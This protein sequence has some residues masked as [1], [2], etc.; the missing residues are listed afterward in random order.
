MNIVEFTAENIKRLKVVRI[1]PD[2]SLVQISGPN[3]SGKS[4]VLDCIAWALGGAALAQPVPIRKG[5]TQAY[6]KLDLGTFV[7]TR[8]FAEGKATTLTVESPDG[9]K[10]P[11]PQRLLDGLVGALSFDPLEFTRLKPRE[12]FD[13]L[14]RLTDLAPQLANLDA[15]SAADFEKRTIVNRKIEDREAQ[16]RGI[17]VPDG[18]P[19]VAPDVDAATRALVTAGEANTQL[20]QRRE[21]R[22]ADLREMEGLEVRADA[23]ADGVAAK[24][25][26]VAEGFD[27]EIRDLEASLSRAR[28]AKDR[29]VKEY[30]KELNNELEGIQRRARELEQ[31]LAAAAPLPDPADVPALQAAAQAARLAADG[32]KLRDRRVAV[33][34][35]ALDLKLE[36]QALTDRLDARKAQKA[37]MLAAA[38]L[39]VPDLGLADG[40]VTLHG[41]PLEQASDAEQ[42]RASCAVAMAA[43][44]KLR[45]LRVKEGSLLDA[46]G[47]ALLGALAEERGYQVWVERV[48]DPGAG[49]GVVLE[50]GEVAS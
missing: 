10:F 14:L 12:Q 19:E 13:A 16:A 23:L 4:T 36:A 48:A 45:V 11:T 37:E 31:K 49:V 22:E 40:L 8:R 7:V 17:T 3:G 20:A 39:P 47:L 34:K 25:S 26:A 5:Q 15:L 2:G 35:Q 38:R 24:V 18:L 1:R 42:L 9:A 29:R 21:R 28:N 46:A 32:V 50:D 27:N 6:I 43:N 44:P 30:A 41:L 33:E